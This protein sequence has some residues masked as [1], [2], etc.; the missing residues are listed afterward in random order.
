MFDKQKWKTNIF[1]TASVLPILLAAVATS[2]A[3]IPDF[4][5]P[6]PLFRAVMQNDTPAVKS[7]LDQGADPNEGLF[8]GF[9]PL[10]FAVFYQNLE[11]LR[12]MI[13]NGADIN[14]RDASGSS[15]LMW[16]A[17]NEQ[18]NTEI[19]R[20]LLKM[21]VD[22]NIKN[23]SGETALTWSLR[24]G[25][26]PVVALLKTSGASDS[27][28]IKESVEKAIGLLQ[29]SG[30]HFAEI[31]GC[32]S[33][34]HQFL[35]Q[36]AVGIAR[37]RGFAVDDGISRD[38]IEAVVRLFEPVREFMLAGTERI[39][40]PALSVSYAL[41]GLGAERYTPDAL[42]HAMAHLISTQQHADG[43]FRALPVRP[44]L[45]SNDF[46]ATTLSL[47]AV[48]LF[49]ADT[50]DG[51]ARA[52]DWLRAAKPHGNEDRVMQLL[53]MTWANAAPE[54]LRSVANALLAEQRPDGGW[55]QL[56]ALG[57][58]AYATGQAL[59]AL[60]LSGQVDVSDPAYQHG[61]EFLLR[62]QQPDGSWHV[63]TRTFPV[64]RYRES[65]FPHGKD[66]FISAAGTSWAAM[67]L[68]LTARSAESEIANSNK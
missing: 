50:E 60:A 53:G 5:P 2:Q 64:Q 66:Q 37:E 48:Q 10:F 8:Q 6:T 61:I 1:I 38:Q 11:M 59:V 67:A 41:N 12:T 45:E 34:H 35:P 49:G 15:T 56:P 31:S 23:K 39:P 63:Q 68:A 30:A 28:M 26:T 46:T 22:P 32:V 54:E 65:G 3:Q 27:A 36:M 20:E 7:I 25:P 29:R 43:S 57:T 4:T 42:T 19:V 47:R 21:G 52:L 33:C 13:E 51:V 9:P 62:I 14:A 24:R 40:D 18:A 17:F 58:D 55:A 44:P 16:A